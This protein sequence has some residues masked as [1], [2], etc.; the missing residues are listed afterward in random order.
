MTKHLQAIILAAGKATRF[1]TNKTK[2]LEPIC[3]QPMVLYPITM[4]A[5][6]EIPI[7]MVVGYQK[8]ELK[9]TLATAT[10]HA[11]H[12]VEQEYQ[13][14]TGHAILCSRDSWEKPT[15]LIMN[16]DM[17]LVTQHIIQ[18]LIQKHT[19]TKAVIS[20]VTAHD[21]GNLTSGYGRVIEKDKDNKKHIE[22]VEARNFI[23]DASDLCC[24]NA[25][26]YLVSKKFLEDYLPT[27]KPNNI[28][29]ELYFTDLIKIASDANLT[30][31]TLSVPFDSIRG[32]NTLQEL[33]EVEQ[34]KRS[35]II[36][37]WMHHGVRFSMP[38]TVHIDLGVTMGAGSII[39][40]NVHLTGTTSISANCTIHPFSSLHNMTLGNNVTIYSHCALSDSQIHDNAQVGPFAHIRTQSILGEHATI[41]NF[42]E[43]KQTSVGEYSK[44]KHLTYLGDA[45]IGRSVN[46][47]AGTIICNYDGTRKHATTIEDNVFIGSNN[48]LVAP[49]TIQHH[50]FTAAGSTITHTVP[51]YTLAFG[52]SR[53]VNKE[54]YK[55]PDSTHEESPSH[56]SP[57]HD[58]PDQQTK[59]FK[60]A[61]KTDV[62]S[63]HRYL[64]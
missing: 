5:S 28:A 18:S 63:T 14:G 7:T 57:P 48:T 32:V 34:I 64:D 23:G 4:L 43:V 53:Q 47:G 42:V 59:S 44:A 9:S 13:G 51:P 11:L 2:L 1:N 15:I 35:T 50:A 12:Y 10:S 54:G 49:L 41:G 3:G 46:I 58:D 37:H 36:K 39:G 22:I 6:L 61:T 21:T 16:G 29:N 20:F 60:G 24:I 38:Q 31:T 45:Q 56:T 33:W 30:V 19:D 25:G 26:I 27:L 55:H 52:R 8:E 40:A 62:D 17:P